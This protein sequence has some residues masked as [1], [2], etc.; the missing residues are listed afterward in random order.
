MTCAQVDSYVQGKTPLI[1]SAGKGQEATVKLLLE[2]DVDTEAMDNAGQRALHHATKNG[3]KEIIRLLLQ[4]GAKRDA[5]DN[6][7]QTAVHLAILKWYVFDFLTIL[8]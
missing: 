6:K 8:Y 2:M 5:K 1:I 3:H 7:R 4:K